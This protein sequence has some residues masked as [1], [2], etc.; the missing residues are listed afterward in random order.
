MSCEFAPTKP[1]LDFFMENSK[2]YLFG[3]LEK[4]DIP[5]SEEHFKFM[6]DSLHVHEDSEIR[7]GFARSLMYLG[8][9]SFIEIMSES[10][11]K[12][13]KL[14][15]GILEKIGR[16]SLEDM[17]RLTPEEVEELIGG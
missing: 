8:F 14:P 15:S 4:G 7:V 10:M 3:T 12:M 1:M 16:M 13:N 11:G 5:D 2:D 6:C 9:K 17:Q